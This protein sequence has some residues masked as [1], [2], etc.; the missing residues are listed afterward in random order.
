[1]CV[2]PFGHY[3]SQTTSLTNKLTEKEQLIYDS[4]DNVEDD[5]LQQYLYDNKTVFKINESFFEYYPVENDTEFWRMIAKRKRSLN[6]DYR[7]LKVTILERVEERN[8]NPVDKYLGMGYTINFPDAERDY[9]YQYYLFGISGILLLI[10]PYVVEYL[11]KIR[12]FLHERE[13]TY[14]N[15]FGLLAGFLG[16]VGAYFSGHLFG[17]TGPMFILVFV[18]GYQKRLHKDES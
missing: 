10:V 13:F 1:M 17:W 12:V 15:C 8:N 6:N 9:I 2:T 7:N 11:K 16:I 18:M 3:F 4:L 14:A 5:D